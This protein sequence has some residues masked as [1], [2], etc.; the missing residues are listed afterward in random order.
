M[1]FSFA[2]TWFFFCMGARF[3]VISAALPA[4]AKG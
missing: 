3:V 4:K 1:T 2:K